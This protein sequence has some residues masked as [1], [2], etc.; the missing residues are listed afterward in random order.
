LFGE[1]F[2]AINKITIEEIVLHFLFFKMKKLLFLFF[3]LLILSS[4]AQNVKISGTVQNADGDTLRMYY[5]PLMLGIKP[6]IITQI[7]GN[8][9]FNFELDID[10]TTLLD[11]RYKKQQII[12]Y[13]NKGDKIEFSFDAKELAKSLVFKGSGVPENTF[14]SKFYKEFYQNFNT[15]QM[16]AKIQDIGVD[17]W[18]MNLFDA[19]KAQSKFY[20][21]YPE[22]TSLSEPFKKYIENQIR[23][24]YWHYIL[25]YPII[26][27]NSNPKQTT[28]MS[29]PSTL[30][31][32]LD[33]K[34]IQ[35]QSA[36]L[37]TSYRNFLIHYVTYFNSK[38]KQFQKYQDMGK[39]MEDK[40]IFAR[41]HLPLK[42][43]QFFLAYILTDKCSVTP[44]SVV[45]NTFSALSITPNSERYQVIAKE[46]CGEIMAKKDEDFT[47]KKEDSKN[48]FRMVT[49]KGDTVSMADLKGKV[50]Y[51]DFWASW[52]GPCRQQFPYSK[53][54]HEMLTEKQKKDV[55]FLYI[56]IDDNAEVWKKAVED[57]KLDN[58]MNGFSEG[59]WNSKAAKFFNLSAIPRYLLINKKGTITDNDAKRPSDTA[60]MMDITKLL[61]E[62]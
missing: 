16:Y 59:G 6:Q 51:V 41:E 5:D 43:Y 30:L 2:V 12:V 29:L 34:K 24:N 22:L 54:L 8:Q 9:P 62:K 10:E 14:L 40:H 55:V 50:V 56:S 3:N 58:G 11:I 31:E 17:V 60:I 32:G 13:A 1:V 26:R 19:K 18:E 46:K 7:I 61:E 53:K 39:N 20:K 15:P 45:R 49:M 35:D 36:M 38:E 57:L 33:E 4:L 44:P 25:A 23:W 21:E 27:G 47:K 48:W 42:A 28:V 37:S 52:C